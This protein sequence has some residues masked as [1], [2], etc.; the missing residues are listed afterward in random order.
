MRYKILLI[1]RN[2]A[3]ID[4]FFSQMEPQLDMLTSSQRYEDLLR[5]IEL[6]KPSALVYCLGREARDDMTKLNSLKRRLERAD[7]SLIAL[8]EKSD[9]EELEDV[10]PG[11]CVMTVA[12]PFTP[13]EAQIKIIKFLSEKDTSEK[14]VSSARDNFYKQEMAKVGAQ[15]GGPRDLMD[16]LADLENELAMEEDIQ[17]PASHPQEAKPAPARPEPVSSVSATLSELVNPQASIFSKEEEQSPA[18]PRKHILIIDDD[19]LMLKIIKDHLHENYDVGS[20]IS[21]KIAYRFLEKRHTDLILLD[22]VMPDENGPSVLRHL[23]SNDNTKDIPVVFLTGMQERGKIQEALSL[24]PQGYL[25]KPVDKKQ[26]M[27]MVK[28]I[29]G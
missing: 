6:V 14:T 29:I 23:R 24:K 21:G 1:G 26:L 20:A 19:P 8:G 2:N 25:L 13:D 27:G 3:L 5:H 16:E 9:L 4:D 28:S 11:A 10:A 22:Y 12:K 7:V 15:N 17:L 18:G